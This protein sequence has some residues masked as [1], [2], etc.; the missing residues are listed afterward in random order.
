MHGRNKK[1]TQ[2]LVENLEGKRPRHRWENI[3]EM[4]LTRTRQVCVLDSN[5]SLKDPV[6]S[7]YEHGTEPTGSI[8]SREFLDQVSNHQN[9][10]KDSAEW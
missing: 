8:R 9:L 7:S 3:I 1:Y 4:D 5:G 6:T 10:K 2:N